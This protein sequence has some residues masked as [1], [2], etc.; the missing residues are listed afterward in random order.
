MISILFKRLLTWC[1][2]HTDV[3]ATAGAIIL[4]AGLMWQL[5]TYQQREHEQ[6]RIITEL[7]Q[8]VERRDA[9]IDEMA[10]AVSH[11]REIS[12]K[13]LTQEQSMRSA[14]DDDLQEIK[15]MLKNNQCNHEPLPY[16]TADK[17]RK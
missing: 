3:V 12:D 16:G 6:T 1:C 4:I 11:W 15:S 9:K 10:E 5:N 2:K 14:A 7:H 17:L 13:L 8:R